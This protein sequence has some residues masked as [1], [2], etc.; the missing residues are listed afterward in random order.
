VDGPY[1]P[2]IRKT[3]LFG[4]LAAVV[5]VFAGWGEKMLLYPNAHVPGASVTI[6]FGPN[7]TNDRKR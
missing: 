2:W 6:R 4:L 7:N 1:L 3:V 5:A